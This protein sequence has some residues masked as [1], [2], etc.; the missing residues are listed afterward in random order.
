MGSVTE[1]PRGE[2]IAAILLY[3]IHRRNRQHSVE[4]IQKHDS[5]DDGTGQH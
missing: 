2:R 1:T 3:L 4:E 5:H